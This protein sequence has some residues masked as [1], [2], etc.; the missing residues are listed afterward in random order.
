MAWSTGSCAGR[1]LLPLVLL[2]GALRTSLPSDP[3]PLC[4]LLIASP[5]CSP[6][7]TASSS[8][9]RPSLDRL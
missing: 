7:L 1:C 6:P 2:V 4:V 9:H 5:A 3:N 8:R